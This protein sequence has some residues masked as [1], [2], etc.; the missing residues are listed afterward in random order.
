MA[1]NALDRFLARWR[2]RPPLLTL[3]LAALL[4]GGCGPLVKPAGFRHRPDSI[5][6]GS[7]LGPFDGRVVDADTG[8][9]IE[10]ALVWCSWA[11]DRGLGTAGPEA[12]RTASV[13][14]DPDGAYRLPLL[15][16]FPQGLSARLARLS[17]IIYRR[18]YVAYRHDRVF[19]QRGPRIDF[20]QRDNVVRLSRWSP[21][22]SHAQ[23][24]L[25]VGGGPELQQATHWE[26]ALATAELDGGGRHASFLTRPSGPAPSGPRPRRAPQAR[27]LLSSDELRA[28]T[29]YQGPLQ[30]GSLAD[31]GDATD[32]IHFR[33]TDRPE[34][35]DVALR[36][37]R[38]T[39]EGL[40]ARYESTLRALPG[41]KQSDEFADRSFSVLQ[42]EILGL[43]LMDRATSTVVLITC[44]RG[45]CA[46]DKVLLKLAR[47]V[48]QNLAR[49]PALGAPAT[50]PQLA[51]PSPAEEGTAP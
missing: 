35:Y 33:A 30:D 34:R 51:P 1:V 20:S 42:G 50:Q 45:Q 15:R 31:P 39:S 36:V 26:A 49:L 25:F 41:S 16:W 17:V 18:G 48:E 21:E 28:V 12:T 6:R 7:M 38:T 8:R 3:P 29:G 2:P 22:L 46:T 11:F 37:W 27:L 32:T 13:R 47:R 5:R 14:T 24:L 23:H 9:P 4:I 10:D 43:G 19:G 40:A 44:G